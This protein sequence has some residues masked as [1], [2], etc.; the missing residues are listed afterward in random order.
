V[1]KKRIRPISSRRR[2]K[3][4]A[5]L[6]AR[7]WVARGVRLLCALI[8][9]LLLLTTLEV[10]LVRFFPPPFT[11]PM[12]A[13]WLRC[14]LH[15]ADC[16]VPSIDWTPIEQISPHLQ[17]AVQAAE[18][19]R[20]PLHSGFDFK[21]MRA[22]L[23]DML[24]EGKV[25]GASTITMQAARSLFLWPDR[26]VGRKLAEAYYTVLM[27]LYLSKKRIL[28]IYLNTVDWGP[29]TLGATAAARRYFNLRAA[30]LTRSQAAMLASILP[31][32]HRWSPT[33]PTPYVKQ[34]QEWITNQMDKIPSLK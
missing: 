31:S 30:D 12:A 10:L 23:A 33:R 2:N 29:K 7:R 22:A 34:R 16:P 32:P 28:E 1:A 4:T 14:T 26:T 21:E 6:L 27:E 17:R 11:V 20:F 18:D 8:L 5:S 9:L 24:F 13:G 25:R 3:G 19:Q 15:S